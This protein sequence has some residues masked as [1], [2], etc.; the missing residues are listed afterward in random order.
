MESTIIQTEV[1]LQGLHNPKSRNP[2]NPNKNTRTFSKYGCQ[3]K[4]L[5]VTY[6][7]MGTPTLSSAL[8]RFTSEFEMGQVVPTRYGHQAKLKSL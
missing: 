6:F 4:S 8:S 2:D 3:I 1:P 7:H 5:A